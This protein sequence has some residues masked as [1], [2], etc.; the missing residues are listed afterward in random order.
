MKK[1]T[2][3]P[4]FKMFTMCFPML[5]KK[6]TPEQQEIIDVVNETVDQ[7]QEQIEEYI[8]ELEQPETQ[9]E[10]EQKPESQ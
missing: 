5:K 8:Q 2:K 4:F 9:N 1:E 3:C 10:E 6:V 7:I